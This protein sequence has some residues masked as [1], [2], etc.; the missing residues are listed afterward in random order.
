MEIRK[1]RK[2]SDQI[3]NR[4]NLMETRLILSNKVPSHTFAQIQNSPI[5]KSSGVKYQIGAVINC[6]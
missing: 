6:N 3:S 4:D 2:R 1:R 5:F